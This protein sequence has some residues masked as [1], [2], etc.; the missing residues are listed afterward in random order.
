M[1]LSLGAN[2][3]ELNISS[4]QIPINLGQYLDYLEDPEGELGIEDVR[5]DEAL[6]WQ[7]STQSIPTLGMTRSAFW[8]HI[9]ISADGISQDDLVLILNDTVIDR[10]EFYIFHQDQLITE[11]VVGDTIAFSDLTVPYRIPVVPLELAPNGQ[12]TNI[13][14]RVTAATGIEIPLSISTIELLTLSQQAPLAFFGA[15]FAFFFVCLF[16]STILYFIYR[17]KQYLN[18]G[19]F[20]AFAITYFLGQSGMGRMWFWG[21]SEEINSRIMIISVVFILLSSCL[22]GQSLKFENRYRGSV[23]LIL[24][25][26]TFA[27][28][29]LAIYFLII[30]FDQIS[31]DN[32]RPIAYLEALVVL[33]VTVMAGITAIQGSRAALYLFFAWLL[34]LLADASMLGYK[35][36]VIERG[37]LAANLGVGLIVVAAL[38]LLGSLAEYVRSKSEEFDQVKLQAKAKGDFLRNVSRE[39]LTPVHL[40]LANSKRLLAAQSNKL[41]EATRQHMGTVIKQSD[42]LHNLINDLLEMAE[43]ESDNFEPEFELLEMSHFLTE[44]KDMM[45]PTAMEKDL[46]ITTEFATA[47]LL[48]QTDKPRLQHALLN[49]ITNAIKFTEHGSI[50]IGYRALYFRRRLGIEIFIRDTGRGM[51]KEFQQK[52][53]NE[54]AREEDASEKNPQG[55]GLGLVIVRRM[56]EKLGGEITFQSEKETGSEFFIRLP[57]RVASD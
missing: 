24:R 40:I 23:N 1:L 15:F 5:N 11:T 22:I 30:P 2:S 6:N 50:L 14:F 3:A 36:E 28:F 46:V 35:F 7:R 25:Y 21:D 16:V 37:A 9:V 41:D 10:V 8:F 54:F 47:N 56:V 20:F 55:T 49:L 32:I 44:V 33:V 51:S 26:L 48:V 45:L 57:L 17:E 18:F 43:L 29:P 39:F 34:I 4:S 53:F 38:L 31:S 42:H 13:Y 52:L 12:E 19:I 27:L